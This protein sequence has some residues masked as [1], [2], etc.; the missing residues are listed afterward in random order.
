MKWYTESEVAFLFYDTVID[1]YSLS[2][3]NHEQENR[4]KNEQV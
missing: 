4:T 3:G 2:Y 1:L